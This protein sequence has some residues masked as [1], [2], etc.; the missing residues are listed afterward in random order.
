MFPKASEISIHIMNPLPSL[1][2]V[3]ICLITCDTVISTLNLKPVCTSGRTVIVRF[4]GLW[5]VQIVGGQGGGS[6]LNTLVCVGMLCAGTYVGH[7]LVLVCRRYQEGPNRWPRSFQP[8][9]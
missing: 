1:I 6:A 8:Q 3:C 9:H 5:L 2:F 7:R 4:C